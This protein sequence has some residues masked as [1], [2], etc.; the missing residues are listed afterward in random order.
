MMAFAPRFL[1]LLVAALVVLVASPAPAQDFGGGGATKENLDLPYDALGE[2]SEEEDA[3][4]VVTFYGEQLEGDGIFYVIDRSGSMGDRGELAIAKQE[5]A[6]NIQEFSERV[7]FGIVFFDA[8]ILKYPSSGMPAQANPGMKASA[9]SFVQSVQNGAGSCVQ[10]GLATILRMANMAT[11][12]RK[13]IVYLG[14]GRGHCQGGDETTYLKNALSSISA[15]NVQRVTINCIMVLDVS[16]IGEDFMKRLAA[17]N[18]GTYT[19]KTR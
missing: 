15:Q 7:E 1:T 8:G 6:K 11:A 12:R 14:D 5:L 3:P 10:Q 4:E 17:M 13:V 2:E 16:A 19:V 9:M 18:S